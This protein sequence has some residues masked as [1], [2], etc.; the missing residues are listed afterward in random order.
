M[1]SGINR[2]DFELIEEYTNQ[3]SVMPSE[4]RKEIEE[5]WGNKPVELYAHLDLDTDLKLTSYWLALGDKHIAVISDNEIGR[6]ILNIRLDDIKNISVEQGL[7]CS[8]LVLLGESGNSP[9]SKN[10][11]YPEAAEIGGKH[12]V[13]C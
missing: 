10:Q 8:T 2:T 5:N 3:P 6:T 13:C 9:S 11:L 4:L 12:P 1:L 7:S